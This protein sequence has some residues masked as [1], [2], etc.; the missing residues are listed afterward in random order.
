MSAVEGALL[1]EL[2]ERSFARAGAA[3]RDSYPLERRMSGD[4]LTTFLGER[5][6]M[7]VATT[8]PSGKPHAAPSSFVLYDGALWLPTVA[9]AARLKNLE[10][11]PNASLVLSDGEGEEHG[12]ILMEGIAILIDRYRAPRGPEALWTSKMGD[13]PEWA[14]IWIVIRPVKLFSYAA[15]GWTPP[16]SQGTDPAHRPG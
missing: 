10:T 7:V 6:F 3:T 2:Q 16:L 15:P 14:G 13:P 4:Q 11:N 9:G 8:R 5:Q 12:A 1:E